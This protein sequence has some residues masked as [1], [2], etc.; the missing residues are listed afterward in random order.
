M[1]REVSPK[2]LAEGRDGTTPRREERRPPSDALRAACTLCA[3]ASQEVRPTTDPGREDAGGRARARD[4]PS[5]PSEAQETPRDGT[6]G[7]EGG[8]TG[9]D[10][11]AGSPTETLL[12]L[13]LP[14][15]DKVWAA[16]QG[17]AGGE[18][19]ASPQSKDLTGS[20]NR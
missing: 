11:S 20:F 1:E 19:S 17:V 5:A 4:D 13:L 14:L 12:R 8:K 3:P 2:T 16:S 6:Q 15:N 9:S 7:V 10:P 18:P